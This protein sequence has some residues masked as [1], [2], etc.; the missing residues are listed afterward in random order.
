MADLL[1]SIKEIDSKEEV[2]Q[3]SDS[4]I[5]LRHIVK[6]KF[7]SKAKEDEIKWGQRSRI[8]WLKEGDRN[9]NFFHKFASYRNRVNRISVLVD[10]DR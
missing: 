4:E 5:S 8:L 10:G 3:L 9:A 2:E 7:L 1:C 6:K